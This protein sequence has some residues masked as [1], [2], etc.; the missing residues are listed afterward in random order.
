MPMLMTLKSP[1]EKMY[2]EPSRFP[3]ET[4][5]VGISTTGTPAAAT[6]AT[7][8]MGGTGVVTIVMISE[9]SDL[10]TMITR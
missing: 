9:A 8:E 5:A 10:T 6:T 4:T 7:T 1:S 3:G 2:K